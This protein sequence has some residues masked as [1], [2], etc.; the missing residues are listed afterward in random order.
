MATRRM[1][2]I[3]AF[4]GV[5]CLFL[6]L[7]VSFAG[8]HVRIV[9]LSEIEGSV[10]IDRNTGQ[11]FEKAIMNMP[12]AQGM[13]IKTTAGRAEV[14]FENGSVVRL[15]DNSS[16][17]FS[18]LTRNDDG[19][20]VNEVRLN[21]GTIY[22][23]YKHKAA[24]AFQVDFAKQS[25]NLDRDV[26]F[27][28]SMYPDTAQLV[29]MKG[30][31]QPPSSA[32]SAKLLKKKQTLNLNL[33]DQAQTAMAKGI[34]ELP[35][36]RWDAQRSAYDTQYQDQYAAMKSPYQYGYTDLNYYGTFF[37]APGY[38]MLWQPFGVSSAW[39]PFGDGAWAFY[40][41]MGYTWVSGYP[42]GWTPYRYGTWVYGPSYG[43]AW[44]PGG[45][46]NI[47]TFP[48]VANAPLS[49]HHP[50]PPG[51]GTAVGPGAIGPATAAVSAMR[52]STVMVGNVNNPAMMH[53]WR[54]VALY[55][56]PN[57]AMTTR[58]IHMAPMARASVV[59][60]PATGAAVRLP[61]Y[62]GAYGPE[63]R[64]PGMGPAGRSAASAPSA[65]MH[66]APSSAMRTG[67]PSAGG[68]RGPA[69]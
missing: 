43:W 35:S 52:N 27:R 10:Q 44:Q 30:E 60:N 46:N 41:G 62:R 13:S 54:R 68:S 22:V 57:A 69:R 3:T 18:Q 31:L 9:R 15:A 12:I 38:G 5:F 51:A 58:G 67:S 37:N 4:T 24:G 6:S 26:H 59:Q 49:W 1:L 55:Q 47:N 39:D 29:V 63:M 16:V 66:S 61:A 2:R 56:A 17:E 65:P 8:S 45:W 36:D 32:E 53:A 19:E 42:W 48:T 34:T 40:P 28:L 20:M 50:V 11:G 23:H 64:S 21:G 14:E 25:V 33:D 7:Q